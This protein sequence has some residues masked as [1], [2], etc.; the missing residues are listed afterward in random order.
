MAFP[1]LVLTTGGVLHSQNTGTPTNGVNT[2]ALNIDP[3]LIDPNWLTIN[4]YPLGSSIQS[5][6]SGGLSVDK[7]TFTITFVQTG[8]DQCRIEAIVTQSLVR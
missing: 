4:V 8:T 6:T 7:T 1:N 2:F 3:D 5:A